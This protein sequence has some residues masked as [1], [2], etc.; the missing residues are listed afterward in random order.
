MVWLSRGN[1]IDLISMFAF[2]NLSIL[3]PPDHQRLLATQF[4]WPPNPRLPTIVIQLSQRLNSHSNRVAVSFVGSSKEDRPQGPVNIISSVF[5]EKQ[6]TII[7]N[8]RSPKLVETI[9]KAATIAVKECQRQFK[10]RKWNCSST[11]P[12]N[13]FGQILQRGE[14]SSTT[15]KVKLRNSTSY[16]KKE[17]QL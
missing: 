12:Y 16:R 17:L 7:K 14:S 10:D 6:R 5:S 3:P 4:N 8:H 13:V 2:T 9:S 1:K 11:N 15:Q